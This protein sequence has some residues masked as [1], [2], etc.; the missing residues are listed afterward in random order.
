MNQKEILLVDDSSEILESFGR[1]LK[2]KGFIV[3]TAESGAEAL[4]KLGEFQ[5][6][7]IISDMRMQPT[8]GL[9]LLARVADKEGDGFFPGKIIFTAFDDDEVIA[10]AKAGPNGIFRVEKDRWETDLDVAITRALEFNNLRLDAWRQGQERVR[11]QTALNMAVT[12]QHG[13]NNPLNTIILQAEEGERKGHEESIVII[14]EAKRIKALLDEATS[15][16][17]V[18]T[19]P[20]VGEGE[21]E[22][23]IDFNKKGKTK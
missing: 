7:L 16:E 8:N 4:E 18:R 10:S 20:Y 17:Q 22:E 3:E 23:L 11:L 14:T 12:L 6:D 1:R 2:R 9:D 5:P 15:I 21:S 13:I 19:K